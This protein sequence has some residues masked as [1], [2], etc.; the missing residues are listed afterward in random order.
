MKQKGR[1]VWCTI[2]SVDLAY[3]LQSTLGEGEMELVRGS[4]YARIQKTIPLKTDEKP[5]IRIE[6]VLSSVPGEFSGSQPILYLRKQRHT[7]YKV[8]AY[9]R[10]CVLKQD[11]NSDS[12]KSSIDIS[13]DSNF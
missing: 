5:S 10:S 2:I 11:K 1:K 12:R 13:V 7:A 8:A 4:D 3:G 9:A 6:D